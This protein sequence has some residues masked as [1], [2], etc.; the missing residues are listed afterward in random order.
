MGHLVESGP[1]GVCGSRRGTTEIDKNGET[2]A[3]SQRTTPGGA[4]YFKLQPELA[5][6]ALVFAS[7]R[8]RRW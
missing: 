6:L 5:L 4:A 1:A 2:N 7:R 8:W 3:P